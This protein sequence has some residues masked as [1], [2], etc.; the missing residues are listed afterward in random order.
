MFDGACSP[1]RTAN[2]KCQ[3]K[4]PSRETGIIRKERKTIPAAIVYGVAVLFL[5]MCVGISPGPHKS[6]RI[7]TV[8]PGKMRPPTVK[9]CTVGGFFTHFFMMSIISTNKWGTRGQS[10][11]CV[12]T[13]FSPKVEQNKKRNRK[14]DARA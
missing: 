4:A 11:Q 8:S 14:T 6:Q 12:R 2:R 1:L 10:L 7:I 9:K 13:L 3:D 5:G